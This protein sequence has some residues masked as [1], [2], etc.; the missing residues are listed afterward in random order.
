MATI[1]SIQTRD[2]RFPLANGAGV[3]AVHA[4]P[5]YSYAVTRLG[6]DDALLGTGFSFT[7]GAGNEV[8]CQLAKELAQPL[9][10][11]DIEQL[12][13]DWGTVSRSIA[14]HP[15]FRWLGPHKGAVHLALASITN[16]CFDLWA[17][18]RGLPL[19]KLLLDLSPKEVVGLLDLS[20]VEDVLDRS[21]AL[22]LLQKADN[23]R[24]ERMGVLDQ[25]YPGYDTSVGWFNYN[26]DQIVANA[27]E[28]IQQGFQA[29]KLKVG[30]VDGQRDVRRVRLVRQ[31]VGDAVSLMVDAN[32]QWTWPVAL[33]ACQRLADL[34]V[35][36]IEE[37]THPDDV[38]GHQRLAEAITP[39]KIAAGEHISNR[40]LFKN[41][42]QARA[43]Q[44]IQV[45]ALRVAG[46]SEFITISLM[47]QHFGLPVIPH[48]G[49]MGQL[50]QHL[51]LFNHIALGMPK[52]FLEHIPHL[53]DHFADPAVVTQGH[54]QTP[55]APGAGMDLRQPVPRP[56]MIA[57]P[58]AVTQI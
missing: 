31:A 29:I 36:W 23:T 40:V 55:Q 34:G 7:L 33:D 16:A 42:M 12:M 24:H 10:G 5:V 11:Q 47:A 1:D 44:I 8:V 46:V 27:K 19:W 50:H 57:R 28:A 21:A 35:S 49:D 39:T 14:D 30:S 15:Q 38:L 20:Y 52:T 26:D 4:D 2:A 32:Q 25:G 41:F 54:Y 13:V 48:V 45:D 6:T 37:P 9:L 17:K 51:V 58:T 3:D 53:R 18:S 43:A 56:H 22:V